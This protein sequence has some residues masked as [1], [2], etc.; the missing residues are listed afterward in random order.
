MRR[1]RRRRGSARAAAT[2]I[3]SMGVKSVILRF[4]SSNLGRC[5]R[6]VAGE[7][8]GLAEGRFPDPC[9]EG[10]AFARN[11]VPT[12]VEGVGAGIVTM[13]IGREG[14]PRHMP[15]GGSP[16]LR[17]TTV[18]GGGVVEFRRRS[19]RPLRS[20]AWREHRFLLH[21]DDALDQDV[22]LAVGALGMDDRD[23]RRIAGTAASTSPVKG[24]SRF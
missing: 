17:S 19:P 5:L 21:A 14:A 20:S 23:V 22:A 18:I 2:V 7:V 9:V 16:P 12:D 10:L 11:L 4:P 8:L 13:R 6:G 24:Q 1:S 15:D 3:I